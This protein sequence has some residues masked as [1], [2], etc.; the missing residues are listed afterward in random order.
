MKIMLKNAVIWYGVFL[1]TAHTIVSII[2]DY[3]LAYQAK[4]PIYEVVP[5][6]FRFSISDGKFVYEA[7][8]VKVE[9][10]EVIPDSGVVIAAIWNDA[11]GRKHYRAY[12]A[13]REN[14]DKVSGNPIITK[15][16]RFVVGPFFFE[17][18]MYVL[19]N[20]SEIT[21]VIVCKFPGGI[22]RTA[23]I[24]PFKVG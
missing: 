19:E 11:D 2:D 13:A 8:A 6:T 16:Q 15:G 17:D 10:C 22:E 1:A 23:T 4:T 5:D 21:Q 14:G 20:I 9:N 18:E 3:K 7:E 12:L 24:G